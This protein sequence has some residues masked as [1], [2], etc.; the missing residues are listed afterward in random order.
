M[1][2]AMMVSVGFWQGLNVKPEAA[3]L[4]TQQFIE[5]CVERPA[6]DVPQRHVH[7]VD[8]T[9]G[10]RPLAPIRTA[11]KILPDVLGLKWVAANDARDD[12]IG[13]IACYGKL[14]AVQRAITQPVNAFVR[15]TLRVTKFLPGEQTK[16]L[17]SLI[18]ICVPRF[19]P[20]VRG[21]PHVVP[22]FITL[23]LLLTA[24]LYLPNLPSRFFLLFSP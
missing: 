12:M 21:S 2:S 1:Q 3:A 18:F 13:E 24:L 19:F 23:R 7:C 11:I 14:A 22:S 15:K 20:L 4:A 10:H 8:R 6:L 9:H 16:T 5:R 17:A